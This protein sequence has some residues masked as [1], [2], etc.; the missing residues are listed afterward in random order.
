MSGE[1]R[2]EK[3]T[4]FQYAVERVEI[5]LRFFL[6]SRIFFIMGHTSSIDYPHKVVSFS[7]RRG[8]YMFVLCSIGVTPS[9]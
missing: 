7:P 8:K 5:S 1:A 6:P 4:L 3:K 2:E 9:R